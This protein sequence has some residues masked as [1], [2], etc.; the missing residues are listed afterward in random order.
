[1]QELLEEIDEDGSGQIEFPE[2]CQE[3]G[4]THQQ[5]FTKQSRH[6]NPNTHCFKSITKLTAEKSLYIPTPCTALGE[7]GKGGG[8][9]VFSADLKIC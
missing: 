7:E 1:V 4:Q 6:L 3:R 2:F 5:L 9:G 8:V